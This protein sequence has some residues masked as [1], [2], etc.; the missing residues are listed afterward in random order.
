M[1]S[2]NKRV[3]FARIPSSQL[4]YAE[5]GKERGIYCG[6]I[7]NLR[8]KVLLTLILIESLIVI[9]KSL[10]LITESLILFFIASSS[11]EG[12]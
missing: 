4:I 12:V 2:G 3:A 9:T 8:L 10:I 5:K 7:I 11:R 1:L 6:K